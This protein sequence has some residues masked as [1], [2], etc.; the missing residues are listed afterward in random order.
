MSTIMMWLLFA[1]VVILI[2][3]GSVMYKRKFTV[4]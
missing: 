4:R 3:F 1:V 2:V